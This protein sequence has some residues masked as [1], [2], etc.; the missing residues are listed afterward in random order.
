MSTLQAQLPRLRDLLFAAIDTNFDIRQNPTNALLRAF[1]CLDSSRS[2]A[3]SR[4]EWDQG[5]ARLGVWLPIN[6]RRALFTALDQNRD[7]LVNL[8]DLTWLWEAN[9]TADEVSNSKNEVQNGPSGL[10][11]DAA[12]LAIA[13]KLRRLQNP[14][15]SALQR[16]FVDNA[17]GDALLYALEGLPAPDAGGE[18]PCILDEEL[19]L[20]LSQA[21]C[22]ISREELR[23]LS[24]TFSFDEGM[25]SAY[26]SQQRI[27]SGPLANFAFGARDP[28]T[29][30]NL[31]N[32]LFA[33]T[34]EEC[35]TATNFSRSR[36]LVAPK[37]QPSRVTNY[38]PCEVRGAPKRL[39]RSSR[40]Y[41]GSGAQSNGNPNK[42][43][44]AFESLR[45]PTTVHEKEGASGPEF[46][47]F[48]WCL[49]PRSPQEPADDAAA[50][51]HVADQAFVDASKWENAQSF[52]APNFDDRRRPRASPT[53]SAASGVLRRELGPSGVVSSDVDF[54]T[55]RSPSEIHEQH[56]HGTQRLGEHLQRLYRRLASNRIHPAAVVQELMEKADA[57]GDGYLGVED[58]LLLTMAEKADAASPEA[59]MPVPVGAAKVL[60]QHVK[61]EAGLSVGSMRGFLTPGELSRWLSPLSPQL[62]RAHS[63]C[64]ASIVASVQRDWG[65]GWWQ[66]A[67]QAQRSE[68]AANLLRS[69]VVRAG[70]AKPNQVYDGAIPPGLVSL[71]AFRKA[72]Q[73]LSLPL[74]V[75]EVESLGSCFRARAPEG[76]NGFAIRNVDFDA[77][78]LFLLS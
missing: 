38:P 15:G 47:S 14:M 52:E 46:G 59:R 4:S 43:T 36:S 21:Q 13:Q 10:Q 68:A 40:V 62:A 67:S 3:V 50:L 25:E 7:E 39:N 49:S 69:A 57:D 54:S 32:L 73:R 42:Q 8:A 33:V 28:W 75:S 37:N 63:R 64:V 22:P 16:R 76:P 6:G 55:G 2:G 23:W 26:S 71:P 44:V 24:R 19:V 74:S 78:V 20:V 5:L 31:N 41:G 65:K 17:V 1:R 48:L 18:G 51:S 66:M 56:E 27:A 45:R 34:P 58:L 35:D 60:I 9:L 29:N 70:V 61:A 30:S 11:N 77:I 12:G 72:V 53:E